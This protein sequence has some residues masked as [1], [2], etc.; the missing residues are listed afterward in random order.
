[1]VLGAFAGFGCKGGQR[2]IESLPQIELEYWT[3]WNEPDDFNELILGYR[4]QHPNVRIT[5]RK[6]TLDEYENRLLQ[7]W[8][9]D[10]GP[11]IFSLPNTAVG[12]HQD[13]ITPLPD[14]IKLPTLVVS[15]GCSKDVR[16]VD[17]PKET[18]QPELLDSTFIPVVADDVILENAIYALPLSADT[19]ALFYNKDLLTA[20][21]VIAPPQTWQELTDMVD[22][23]RG[24]LTKEENGAIVQAGIALGTAKNVNRATDVLS[25][26]MMQSGAE[27]VDASG[28]TIAFDRQSPMDK[29][30]VPGAS[31]LNYYTSFA[32]PSRVTYSW[33][34]DM[35]E[36][37]ESFASGQSAF[38][39]GYSYQVDAIRRA[40]PRLNFGIAQLPQ[41]SLDGPQINYANYW[42][43]SVAA[44]SDHPNESWDF[45]LYASDAQRVTSYLNATKKP[46]AVKSLLAS[47]REDLDLRV[48]V[49]QL[50]IAKSWYHG[51]D[52]VAM[53]TY[54]KQMITS[55]LDGTDPNA[56]L[57]TAARQ[58]QETLRKPK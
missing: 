3:V 29:E 49:D 13:L 40:N 35:P 55:V 24:G 23:T 44:Q 8:A 9:R 46:T 15:G 2:V 1:M 6:M 36:A 37:Q 20:A 48:F 25:V 47:Q 31:A 26:L 10:E 11:D 58:V 34:D 5:V 21:K 16:V 41:I 12:K 57:T 51:Y 30:Y 17:R 38:F 32:N 27:M 52:D 50:L 14:S 19:L 56:A 4:E 53:E 18:I 28:L 43:E 45:L 7:A 39:L 42:V 22:S 54:M 33:N